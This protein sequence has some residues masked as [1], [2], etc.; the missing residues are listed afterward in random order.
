MLSR[1]KVDANLRD[2]ATLVLGTLEFMELTPSSVI[3]LAPNSVA[4]LDLTGIFHSKPMKLITPLLRS[5]TLK[6]KNK[7]LILY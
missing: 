1:N 5:A 7:K 2:L 3:T 4:D 6:Q